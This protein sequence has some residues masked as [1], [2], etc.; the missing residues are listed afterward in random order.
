MTLLG[1]SDTTPN[2]LALEE[3]IQVIALNNARHMKTSLKSLQDKFAAA[4]YG[5]DQKD[6]QWLVAMLFKQGRVTMTLSSQ[7]LS[8]LSTDAKD[9]VR[10]LTKREFVEKLLIDIRERAT[11]G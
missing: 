4:P 5:F 11:D 8:L 2:K 6:V 7:S 9:I 1:T 3:V 10:Y